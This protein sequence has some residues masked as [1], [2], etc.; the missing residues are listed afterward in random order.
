MMN[1]YDIDIARQ[2]D[3]VT[4]SKF[5]KIYWINLKR[6]ITSKTI[7]NEFFQK[8]KKSYLYL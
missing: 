7:Q 5:I 2:T 6:K 1:I 4:I 3:E 8:V